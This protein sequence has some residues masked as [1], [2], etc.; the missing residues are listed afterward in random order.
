MKLGT[1]FKMKLGISFTQDLVTFFKI[2]TRTFDFLVKNLDETALEKKGAAGNSNP[3]L[4]F[5]TPLRKTLDDEVTSLIPSFF[6]LF[7]GFLKPPSCVL[8]SS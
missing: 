8:L 6:F 3:K 2:L 5:G 7:G 4:G 1:M